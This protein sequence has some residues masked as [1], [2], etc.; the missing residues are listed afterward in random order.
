ML[1]GLSWGSGALFSASFWPQVSYR[2]TRHITKSNPSVCS[3]EVTLFLARFGCALSRGC[4]VKTLWVWASTTTSTGGN[5]VLWNEKCE[6]IGECAEFQHPARE[7]LESRESCTGWAV[8]RGDDVFV[9]S[10]FIKTSYGPWGPPWLPNTVPVPDCP[11]WLGSKWLQRAPW[12][13]AKGFV[14]CFS[15]PTMSTALLQE[16]LEQLCRWQTSAREMHHLTSAGT[17]PA[18]AEPNNPSSEMKLVW[19]QLQPH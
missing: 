14:M 17:A 7:L 12:A 5:W 18:S 15:P 10:R 9:S 8:F 1:R 13:L 4:A 3:A 19:G 6:R 16:R 11:T 2:H